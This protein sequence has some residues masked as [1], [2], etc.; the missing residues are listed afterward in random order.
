LKGATCQAQV[1]V[2]NGSGSGDVLIYSLVSI[3][4]DG[5][6]V[7]GSIYYT[8]NADLSGVNK[9]FETMVNSMLKGQSAG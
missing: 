9:N 4:T 3:R 5:L 2:T 7:V 8:K 6:A 1:T